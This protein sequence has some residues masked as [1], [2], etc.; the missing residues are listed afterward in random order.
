MSRFTQTSDILEADGEWNSGVQVRD[1]YDTIAGAVYADGGTGTIFIEQSADGS[2]WD[3]S[4]SYTVA[5]DDGKGFSESLLLPYWR[6]RYV[7]DGDDQTAFRISANTQG[8]G[9]S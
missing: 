2:N 9:D 8:A 7:N 3:I 6:I 1:R 5:A 4:T